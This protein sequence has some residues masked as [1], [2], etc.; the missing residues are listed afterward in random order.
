MKRKIV[1]IITIIVIC[2]SM[3]LYTFASSITDLNNKKD[4]AANNIKEEKDKLE[5]VKDQKS[6]AL[7]AIDEL[8]T[9]IH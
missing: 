7:A 2:L 1:S 5:E 6:E 8:I 3:N 9:M 4:E